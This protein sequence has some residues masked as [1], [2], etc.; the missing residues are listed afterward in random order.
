VDFG[1]RGV[2]VGSCPR[3]CLVTRQ[4][5]GSE[6]KEKNKRMEGM[7]KSLRLLL[8]GGGK[9]GG[10]FSARF[11]LGTVLGEFFP[12]LKRCLW[13]LTDRNAF[14]ESQEKGTTVK[15]FTVSQI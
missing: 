1:G 8:K 4:E 7:R 6:G 12:P 3:V 14:N 11:K 5:T 2:V 13:W 15:L 10:D 9:D